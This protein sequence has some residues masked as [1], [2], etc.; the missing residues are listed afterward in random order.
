MK[1][2][3][4]MSDFFSAYGEVLIVERTVSSDYPS[5]CDVNREVKISL[6][7]SLSYFDCLWVRVQN[8]VP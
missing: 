3:V 4:T 6:K 1:S 8:L 2:L 7:E 5:L